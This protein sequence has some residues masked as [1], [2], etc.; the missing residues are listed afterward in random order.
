M[1]LIK[2]H[3]QTFGD[4]RPFHQKGN[5]AVTSKVIQGHQNQDNVLL[6]PQAHPSLSV[7][8]WKVLTKESTKM[9]QSK[10]SMHADIAMQTFT[11]FRRR[12]RRGVG[13]R[14]TTIEQELL[15]EVRQ[16]T[17]QNTK[18]CFQQRYVPL[19]FQSVLLTFNRELLNSPCY[20]L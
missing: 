4:T 19:H 14:E 18:L 6:C 20:S 9:L 8:L 10:R 15:Q 11:K 3:S 2:K 12:S 17:S 16:S 7:R 5:N 1:F 13:E